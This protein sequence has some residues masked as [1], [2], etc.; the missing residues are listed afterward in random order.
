MGK[1]VRDGA[2]A[3]DLESLSLSQLIHQHVRIA[4]E[5]AVHEVA[6]RRARDDALR[7]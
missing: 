5:T 1:S 2:R 7:A 6:A 3:Q 4:I